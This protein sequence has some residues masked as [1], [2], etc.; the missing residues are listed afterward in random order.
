MALT[1]EQGERHPGAGISRWPGNPGL[2]EG[3]RNG[4]GASL[5]TPAPCATVEEM[6][7][8]RTEEAV[9]VLDSLPIVGEVRVALTELAHTLSVRR[10]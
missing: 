7:H 5:R 2:G 4:R 6:I 10:S 9:A 3:K 8:A 1:R